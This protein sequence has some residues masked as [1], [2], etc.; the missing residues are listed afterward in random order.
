M[1]DATK[2]MRLLIF[3]GAVNEESQLEQT[4]RGL[5]AACSPAHVA[6]LMVSLAP[7]AT[8]GCIRTAEA[9]EDVS[10]PI[11]IEIYRQPVLDCP[12]SANALL[13]TRPDITHVMF[14]ASDYDVESATVAGMI[15]RAAQ[16]CD[17]VY[18]LSRNLR[19]GRFSAEYPFGMV[20][21]YR[22]F[23]L[24]LRIGFFS[25]ITDPAFFCMVAPVRL[26]RA[27]R[28]REKSVIFG[29]EW[30]F[31]LLRARAPTAELPAVQLPRTE[32]AGSS[33]PLGRLRYVRLAARARFA[34]LKDIWDEEMKG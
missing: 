32:G 9:L 12:F 11:P 26:F 17:T 28:F 5:A 14:L 2:P 23:T 10:A 27:V 13:D 15:A 18:K 16:D 7:M 21:S 4:V 22:L 3:I 25:R 34:P 30:A 33:T 20:A 8:E 6:S 29:V 19:G 1:S 24:L 31:T